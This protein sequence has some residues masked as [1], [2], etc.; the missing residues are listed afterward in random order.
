MRL[1][2]NFYASF[3]D[4]NFY[5]FH[6]NLSEFRLPNKQSM[7]FGHITFNST[8]NAFSRRPSLET[9]FSLSAIPH[10]IFLCEHCTLNLKEFFNGFALMCL[11]ECCLSR[12]MGTNPALQ[13]LYGSH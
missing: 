7:E 2:R 5:L 9:F 3:F 4:G 12:S 10:F 8:G 13:F 6:K 11:K 1:L